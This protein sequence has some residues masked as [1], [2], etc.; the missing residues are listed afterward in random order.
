MNQQRIRAVFARAIL[1]SLLA[2]SALAL[3]S[4]PVFAQTTCSITIAKTGDGGGPLA[5]AQFTLYADDGDQIFD[6]GVDAQSGDPA[7]TDES[8]AATFPGLAC[9]DF[10]VVETGAPEGYDIIDPILVQLNAETNADANLPIEDA[11]AATPTP[12]PAI[13]ATPTPTP[14]E[15]PIDETTPPTATPKRV[16]PP[17]PALDGQGGDGGPSP[18]ILGLLGALA[19]SAG[20]LFV[21]KQS[22]KAP[23]R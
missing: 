8:G 21:A 1:G 15:T 14:S 9:S 19:L 22:S 7:T 23:R 18:L 16:T 13:E 3:M 6:A 20:L 10:F 2:T 4:A 11:L 12:T 17:T 5:G